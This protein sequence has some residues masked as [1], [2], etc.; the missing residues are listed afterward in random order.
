MI[1]YVIVTPVRDEQEFLPFTYESV[2]RQTLRPLEWVIVNDGSKDW[3]G[4]LID[5]YSRKHNWIHA[6]HRSD[7]GSRRWGG[8]IIEAFYEGFYALTHRDWEFMA[9]L[10]GDLSFEPDYF[11]SLFERC[12]QNPNLGICGGMLYHFENGRMTVERHPLFHV[13]GGVKTYRRACWDALEG[14]WIGPGSDTLDEVKAQ[15]LGW[16]TRSFPDL[17]LQHHR[18]TGSSWGR[19]GGMVKNGKTDYVCGYHPLFMAAKAVTRLIERPYVLG[20]LALV[21]GYLAAYLHKLPQVDDPGLIRYLRAQQMARL[22]GRQTI[23]R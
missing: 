8:G 5:C 10:D 19:W 20:S 6:V 22:A 12:A 4:E 21:C 16:N 15:M 14:L 18:A 13:R 3:T 17:Q 9:K 7:R 2:V 23:W 11:A 1:R